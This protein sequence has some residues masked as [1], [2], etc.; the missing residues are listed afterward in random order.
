MVVAKIFDLL[1][2]V[3]N[4][5]FEKISQMKYASLN[6]LIKIAFIKTLPSISI[7]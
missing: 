4:L 2:K 5:E 7:K 1:A 3:A 6:L